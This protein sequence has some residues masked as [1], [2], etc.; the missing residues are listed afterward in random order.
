MSG[1]NH[2]R[3]LD[4]RL[5]PGNDNR[6]ADCNAEGLSIA[7]TSADKTLT[8]G[9]FLS[10]F[11]YL[12]GMFVIKL[13]VF[14]TVLWYLQNQSGHRTALVCSFV[15][16]AVEYTGLWVHILVKQ[17]ESSLITGMMNKLR[18]VSLEAMFIANLLYKISLIIISV[19]ILFS[20][21]LLF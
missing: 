11:L 6:C 15:L 12:F 2:R 7:I 4:I 1:G 18:Q 10:M 5:K 13:L 16:H 14:S 3:L 21:F 17:K 9:I 8:Y 20:N 19:L